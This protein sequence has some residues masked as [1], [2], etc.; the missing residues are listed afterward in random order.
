MPDSR[1]LCG[2][3]PAV[4]GLLERSLDAL[5]GESQGIT[6][7][8]VKLYLFAQERAIE[9]GKEEVTAAVIRSAAQDKPL[10]RKTNDLREVQFETLLSEYKSLRH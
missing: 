9:S 2:T 8:A 10:Q 5:Y 1:G 6:D 3:Q 7:F 4:N